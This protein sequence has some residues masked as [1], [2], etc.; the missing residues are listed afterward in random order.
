MLLYDNA[1]LPECYA[2]R[3]LSGLLGVELDLKTVDCYPGRQHREEAFLAINPLGTLPVLDTGD[4]FLRDWLAALVYLAARYDSSARWLPTADAGRLAAVQEWLSIARL[5]QSSAGAARLH[6]SIGMATDIERRRREAH[7]LL[8]MTEKHLWFGERGG[9]DWLV[10]GAEPTI[11]D[12]ALFVHVILS[13]EGGIARMPYPAVRRW[14]ERL[15]RLPN[16]ALMGG[17]FPMP[18]LDASRTLLSETECQ[19]ASAQSATH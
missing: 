13:E 7:D 3:L 16:F 17:V 14:T 4:A 8:R 11:A 18:A 15:R 6:D 5:L 12:I 2:V 10:A 19:A 9:D 1:M